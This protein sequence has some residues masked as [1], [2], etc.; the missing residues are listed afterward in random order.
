MQSSVQEGTSGQ[1]VEHPTVVSSEIIVVGAGLAGTVASAVL[2]RRGWRVIL[3]DPRP[4]CPPVLKAEKIDQ[5]P[6]RLLRKFGLLASMLPYAGQVREVR[7]AY[8]GR[9]FKT[10]PFEQYGIAYAD[11]V[12][13]LRADMPPEVEFLSGRVETIANSNGLQQVRLVGGRQLVARLVVLASGINNGIQAHLSFRRRLFQREQSCVFGFTVSPADGQAF[14]FDSLTYYSI[15]PTTNVDY[16]T[17]FRFRETMRANL[18]VFR[19]LSDPW[20]REFVKEPERMLHTCLAK[21]DRVTGKLRVVSR[22][23][24]GRAGLCRLEGD[25]PPG[26]AAI[27]DCFQSVCPSTGMGLEKILTDVEALSEC[28]PD[29]MA[30]PGMGSDKLAKF[31]SHPRKLAVDSRALQR[32]HHHRLAVTDTSLR[33]RVYRF[34]LHQKWQLQGAF[35]T[36]RCLGG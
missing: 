8:N 22:V 15:D 23:E 14:S 20:A 30:T 19:A 27:G 1:T 36:L 10:F 9:V 28:V 21:L 17:L 5:E 18:F 2:G 13:A 4:C 6:V 3:V 35:Q 33:W 24:S 29:W 31:Y 25:P 11:M 26:V 32:A 16:L 12:N 7:T 34:L